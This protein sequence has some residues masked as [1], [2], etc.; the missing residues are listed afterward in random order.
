MDQG[1]PLEHGQL[2]MSL[3]RLKKTDPSSL[4]SPDLPIVLQLGMEYFEPFLYEN[5]ILIYF[6]C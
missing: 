6:I 1:H 2:T 3:T 5:L 4:L